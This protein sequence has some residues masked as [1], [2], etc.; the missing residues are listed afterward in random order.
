MEKKIYVDP[1]SLQPNP[2]PVSDLSDSQIARIKT[3]WEVFSEHI[4]QGCGEWT[5]SFKKNYHPEREILAWEKMA[6]SYQRKM[7]TK[8]NRNKRQAIFVKIL[9]KS[10]EETPIVVAE[11]PNPELN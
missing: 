11:N 8:P 6:A 9:Q 7:I 3:V 1:N 10:M 5:F 2:F 4:S